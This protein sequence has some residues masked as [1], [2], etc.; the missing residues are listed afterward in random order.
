MNRALAADDLQFSRNRDV[1]DIN[2]SG[3]GAA[4]PATGYDGADS[5]R[6]TGAM[7]DRQSLAPPP[8]R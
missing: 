4:R 5:R 8:R 6:M 1:T 3:G 2:T 7:T